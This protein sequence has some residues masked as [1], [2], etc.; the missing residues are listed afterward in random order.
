MENKEIHLE[1]HIKNLKKSKLRVTNLV[2]PVHFEIMKPKLNI[3]EN[4]KKVY[5]YVDSWK[6]GI[7][8][9]AGLNLKT[10]QILEYREDGR[11]IRSKENLTRDR[12]STRLNSSHVAIS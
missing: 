12:K 1:E 4:G 2:V 5:S 7:G 10:T 6:F 11:R 9:Y 8:G 3:R